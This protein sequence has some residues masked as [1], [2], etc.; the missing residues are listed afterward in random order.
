MQPQQKEGC[1][2]HID[3]SDHSQNIIGTLAY[4]SRTDE[5]RW[6][7]GCFCPTAFRV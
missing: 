6:Y 3:S 5:D 2:M 1:S 4:P 7:H